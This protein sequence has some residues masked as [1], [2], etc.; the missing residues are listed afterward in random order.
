MRIRV[1]EGLGQ[2]PQW[3]CELA[4]W[5]EEHRD[6]LVDRAVIM[7]MDRVLR[8]DD[9]EQQAFALVQEGDRHL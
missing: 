2:E 9:A 4:C 6:W 7:K 8:L 3:W 5:P 1:L